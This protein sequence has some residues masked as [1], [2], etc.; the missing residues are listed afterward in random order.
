MFFSTF[1]SASSKGPKGKKQSIKVTLVMKEK[2]HRQSQYEMTKFL[3]SQPS[4]KKA[5][6]IKD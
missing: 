3:S 1:F 6:E 2:V 4:P 5:K